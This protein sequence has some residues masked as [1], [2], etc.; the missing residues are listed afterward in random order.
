MAAYM[1]VIARVH[2]REQ[3]MRGYAPRAAGLIERFGGRYLLRLPNASVLEGSLEPGQSVV[4]SEWPDRAAAERFWHSAEYGEVKKLRE[5]I[6]DA[7][8]LL[9][10]EPAAPPEMAA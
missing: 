10:E 3:F 6:C 2:D 4:V 7:Q 8:V 9:L 5:G 1:I